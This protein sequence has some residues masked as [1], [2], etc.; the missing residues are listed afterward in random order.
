MLGHN[1]NAENTLTSL[2]EYTLYSTMCMMESVEGP[3]DSVKSEA[4]IDGNS[5]LR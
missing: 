4:S 3:D 1:G 5:S 2:Q